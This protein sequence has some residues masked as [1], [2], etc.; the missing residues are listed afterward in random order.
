MKNRNMV[1]ILAL[2]LVLG[3]TV[4]G[5]GEDPAGGSGLSGTSWSRNT[6]QSGSY[7]Y[8][9]TYT[10]RFTSGTEM[11]HTQKGWGMINGKKTNYNTTTNGTYTYYPE[12]KEGWINCSALT[13]PYTF[14]IDGDQMRSK[15]VSAVW[16]KD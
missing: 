2:A 9:F 13:N 1:G 5:C 10:I 11:S 3:M 6:S 12:I 14:Y 7:G 4:V 15:V 8:S 16:N